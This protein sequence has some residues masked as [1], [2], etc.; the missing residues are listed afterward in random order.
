M[1]VSQEGLINLEEQLGLDDGQLALNGIARGI[2]A[3]E[4]EI[5]ST[6]RSINFNNNY[7]PTHPGP[8]PHP[9]AGGMDH[10]DWEVSAYEYAHADEQQ[11]EDASYHEGELRKAEDTLYDLEEDKENVEA[12]DQN[13]IS[14]YATAERERLQA[15]L[16]K[17]RAKQADDIRWEKLKTG[18]EIEGSAELATTIESLTD[19]ERLEAA[20]GKTTVEGW[21]YVG[22]DY[23]HKGVKRFYRNSNS[24]PFNVFTE[25]LTVGPSYNGKRQV[26][27]LQLPE[28][29][30]VSDVHAKGRTTQKSADYYSFD[31]DQDGAVS[32]QNH[33]YGP[34][35]Q[36]PDSYGRE[37]N[38]YHAGSTFHIKTQFME[39][40][41][42]KTASPDARM[43]ADDIAKLQSVANQVTKVVQ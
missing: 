23:M 12:G 19:P 8:R 18:A 39:K 3:T 25:R 22:E 4:A 42:S 13:V 7:Q 29:T 11:E 40:A 17:Q 36:G 1:S 41:Y 37:E 5:T 33:A 28:V 31:I 10:Q 16:E 24:G 30:G 20:K 2:A 35:T 32:Q 27:Y 6:E 38:N 15:E 26:S 14:K 9:E 43:D 34:V 21:E